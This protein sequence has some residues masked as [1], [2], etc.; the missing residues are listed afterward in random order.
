MQITRR[1]LTDLWVVGR[2]VELD[3]GTTVKDEVT[4]EMRP[5]PIIIWLQK[6]NAVETTDTTRRSDAQRARTL[7]VRED[8]DCDEWQAIQNAVFDFISTNGS[9]KVVDFLLLDERPKVQR[10]HESRIANEDEWSKDNYLMGL[11]DAWFGGL[12]RRWL[13]NNDDLEAARCKA[14]LD[15]YS[16]EVS[17]AVE[18]EM[19][20]LR[21]NFRDRTP[22]MLDE[23]MCERLLEMEA[24]QKWMRELWK[25]QLYYGARDPDQRRERVFASREEV[26]ELTVVAFDFLRDAYQNLEVD[27][28]EGKE[29]EV[30]TPSSPSSDQPKEEEM[31]A[32]SGLVGANP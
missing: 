24:N 4:G 31:V 18:N 6:L 8:H 3:D 13:E 17:E 23:A 9:E 10:N 11:R 28:L 2:L 19:D 1:R 25:S 22:D 12:E 30:P 29:L 20:V 32:A 27:V 7:M 16:T 14:A 15:R 26:D 21:D 5:D